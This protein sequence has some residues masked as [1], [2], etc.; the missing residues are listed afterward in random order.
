MNRRSE[1]THKWQTRIVEQYKQGLQELNLLLGSDN[2]YKIL[3]VQLL[4]NMS[5]ITEGH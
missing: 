1:A 3:P 2:K 4:Y 5:L